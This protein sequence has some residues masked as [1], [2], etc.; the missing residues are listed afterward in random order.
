MNRGQGAFEYLLIIGGSVMLSAI[1]LV[2]VNGGMGIF[3]PEINT[4]VSNI[5]KLTTAVGTGIACSD[6]DSAFVN[7]NEP[8]SVGI[9]MIRSASV[10][11]ERILDHSI[12]L[13]DVDTSQIQK[14]VEATC[15]DGTTMVK[16]NEDGTLFC[17]AGSWVIDGDDLSNRNTGMVFISNLNV[18]KQFIA[19][20]IGADKIDVTNATIDNLSVRN[21]YVKEN[22]EVGMALNATNLN[23][24]SGISAPGFIVSASAT[25]ATMLYAQQLCMRKS[26]TDATYYCANNWV[27]LLNALFAQVG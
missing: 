8:N 5:N 24:K 7:V 2:V 19:P 27:E 4:S 18:T 10:D 17:D 13:I 3:S 6:C 14:R 1:A 26:S 22:A 20:G 23:A 16:I 9:G 11:S 15:P 12:K 21:I 25:N